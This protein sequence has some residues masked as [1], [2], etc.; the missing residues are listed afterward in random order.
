MVWGGGGNK[1]WDF[2]GTSQLASVL[3]FRFASEILA[4]TQ[5]LSNPGDYMDAIDN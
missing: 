4:R 1:D 5:L 2:F 3:F